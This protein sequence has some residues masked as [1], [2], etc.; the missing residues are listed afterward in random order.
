MWWA[1]RPEK[2]LMISL[3][4]SIQYVTDG[5]TRCDSNNHAPLCYASR[6]QKWLYF[7]ISA[8]NH[9]TS[10]TFGAQMRI[11]IPR[12]VTWRKIRMLLILDGGWMLSWKLVFVYIS[13]SCCPINDIRRRKKKKN[14]LTTTMQYTLA[15]ENH[16]TV[17]VGCRKGQR[18]Q[19]RPP[20]T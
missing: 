9:P 1:T 3:S 16:I 11:L 17:V 4:V 8:A 14:L 6:K 15:K 13:A 7:Y 20:M 12:I 10:M 2:S 18:H 19:C 5:Q